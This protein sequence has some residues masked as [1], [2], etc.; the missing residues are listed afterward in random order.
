M[1]SKGKWF[2]SGNASDQCGKTVLVIPRNEGSGFTT[3]SHSTKNKHADP[4]FVGM[5]SGL[6]ALITNFL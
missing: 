1:S 2:L 5:T 4:S 3:G 6:S